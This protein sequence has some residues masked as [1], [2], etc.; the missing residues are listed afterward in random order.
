M[1]VP[2]FSLLLLLL[3][4]LLLSATD[5]RALPQINDPN[6]PMFF[7][8]IYHIFMQHGCGGGPAVANARCCRMGWPPLKPG[9]TSCASQ[10][11]GWAHLT[12]VD[13]VH[14]K[15]Q[16]VALAPPFVDIAARTTQAELGYQDFVT[17]GYF[18]GSAQIVNGQP[19]LLF[20]AVFRAPNVT[21]EFP[22]SGQCSRAAA[23]CCDAKIATLYKRT[24]RSS[25]VH[26]AELHDRE[27]QWAAEHRLLLRPAA[28]RA[29]KSL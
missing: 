12:S 7:N 5:S 21:A 6:G 8:G 13:A 29:E 2:H 20:P 9:G 17:T 28:G 26:A 1:A 10:G 23:H 11:V 27:H 16:P 24:W 25:G 14:W 3:L 18:T 19:R 4:L 15:E 22:V